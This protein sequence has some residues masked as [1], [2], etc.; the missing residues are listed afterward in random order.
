MK[1]I[2]IESIRAE[3]H[4]EINLTPICAIIH[5]TKLHEVKA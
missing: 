3:L 2:S 4:R 1:Q 5:G